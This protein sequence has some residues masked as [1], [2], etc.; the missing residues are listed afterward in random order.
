MSEL[1]I[2]ELSIISCSNEGIFQHLQVSVS[3]LRIQT[4]PVY[5]LGLSVGDGC[6][7][8]LDREAREMQHHESEVLCSKEVLFEPAHENVGITGSKSGSHGCSVCLDEELV[9]E[10]ED[11]VVKDE[12]DELYGGSWK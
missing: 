2:D 4:D 5:V 9:V 12:A 11:I 7:N 8:M 6:L 1:A 10:A 3:F